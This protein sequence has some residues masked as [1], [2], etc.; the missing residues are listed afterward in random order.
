MPSTSTRPLTRLAAT[1]AGLMLTG[2]ALTSHAL[3]AEPRPIDA[4]V[5]IA[6]TPGAKIDAN[7]YGQFIEVLGHGIDGGIYVGEKSPIPNTRGFR[8]D[9]IAAFKDIKVPLVRWPGGCFADFYHWRDGI[10]PKDKRPITL[11][12]SWGGVEEKNE[13][14]T[15]EFFD[16]AELIGAKIYLSANVGTG[17]PKEMMD[18]LEYISSD[19]KSALAEERRKNGRDKPWK[20]DYLGIGNETWGCGG[21]MTPE[22]SADLHNQY[23]EFVRG[24][25]E[26]RPA[27]IASG[28]NAEDYNWTEVLM[29][30]SASRMDGISLHYYTLPTGK[31]DKKGEGVGFSEAEWMKT[32]VQTEKMETLLTKHTAIMDKY[33]PKKRVA[34]FVDEWG[35]WYD[36]EPGSNKSFL[37]QPNTLRDALVAAINLNTFH[38]HADRVRMTSVAQTVNVLQAMARTKEEK[39]YL[40]PTYQVFKI[41]V[42]FQNA[43]SLAAN[44]TSADYVVGDDK[45]K[46]VD[47][48]AARGTDG[49]IYV[50]LVNLDPTH[51]ANVTALYDGKPLTVIAGQV[52][53]AD[54]MDAGN[55]FEAPNALTAKPLK[56]KA[57]G[58]QG[59]VKIP[60]KSVTVLEIAAP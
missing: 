19:T 58:K 36:P 37:E 56:G 50:S 24:P 53:T 3:A 44:V 48:S 52:I 7:I 11:N 12:Y 42:P 23:A 9:L 32:F 51:P 34:L 41:Y 39:M 10:G 5:E 13:V 28:A 6:A 35:T 8:N 26:R 45:L 20:V 27:R 60:A 25:R 55:S 16:F 18:W 22:Y 17:S 31:W 38:R 15:H 49:K 40:T 57:L 1:L 21:S 47:I 29:K 33:D 59:V 43:T 2:T 46:A 54:K 14:G 30:K 4:R